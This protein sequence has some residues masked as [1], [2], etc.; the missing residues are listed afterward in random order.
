MKIVFA[1]LCVIL[2]S[3]SALKR[4]MIYVKENKAIGVM[5]LHNTYSQDI[6]CVRHEK[7]KPKYFYVMSREDS[8]P[9]PSTKFWCALPGKKV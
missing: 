1:L 9:F 2:L 8:E 6:L 7:G 5:V 3:G 4:D